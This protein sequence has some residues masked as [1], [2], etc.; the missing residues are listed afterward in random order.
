MRT[1]LALFLLI[2]PAA[3]LA[4]DRPNIVFMLSDDQGWNGL[5]VQMHP[6]LAALKG[7]D[8]HTPNLER[9]AAEGMPAK[10][11]WRRCYASAWR[12]TWPPSTP[13]SRRT[14]PVTIPVALLRRPRANGAAGTGPI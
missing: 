9:L 12:N 2:V 11:Q 6:D 14:I 7:D 3:G 13:S 1:C 10:R 8:F 4:A 5:S